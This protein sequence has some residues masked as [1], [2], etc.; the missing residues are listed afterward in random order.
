MDQRGIG[1]QTYVARRVDHDRAQPVATEQPQQR[2][3]LPGTGVASGNLRHRQ[4][5]RGEAAGQTG[6]GGDE[7]GHVSTISQ[8]AGDLGIARTGPAPSV[9]RR[10]QCDSQGHGPIYPSSGRR[11]DRNRAAA[12]GIVRSRSS[13]GS[14]GCPSSPSR[15]AAAIWSGR[16][17]WHEPGRLADEL[18][19][20]RDVRSDDLEAAPQRLHRRDPE[21]FEPAGAH[22]DRGLAVRA[23]D[24]RV[25][26]GRLDAAAHLE[27][28]RELLERFLLR[29]LSDESYL[30]PAS[31]LRGGVEDGCLI[32]VRP[33]PGDGDQ[34]RWGRFRNRWSGRKADRVVAVR[35]PLGT[36]LESF[37]HR[38]QGHLAGHPHRI[39]RRG[40]V[41]E[42]AVIAAAATI[43]APGPGNAE[44]PS[45]PP[46]TPGPAS[47]AR[48]LAAASPRDRAAGGS[49]AAGQS[50]R[51]SRR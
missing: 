32:L 30:D 43:S 44:K 14:P 39:G 25:V 46:T 3:H 36:D 38:L 24:R 41:A 17:Q 20:R 13:S 15:M 2:G 51:P 27:S 37:R 12:A 10:K 6:H 42:P 49:G 5:E 8:P 19:M 48:Y 45:V 31:E 22:R 35:D 9:G 47:P 50:G 29:P 26:R 11:R 18:A 34:G 4:A 23:G 40:D 1:G 16:I 28:A 33:E 7:M 21:P